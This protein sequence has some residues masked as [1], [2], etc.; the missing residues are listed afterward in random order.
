MQKLIITVRMNEYAM[1]DE[2]PNVPWSPDEIAEDAQEC[3]EAGAACVHWHGRDPV[4]GSPLNT[5]ETYRDAILKIRERSD[6]MVDPTLGYVT[7]TP[8]QRRIEHVLELAKDPATRPELA[9]VDMASINVDVYDEVEKRFKTDE[10]VFLNPTKILMEFTSKLQNAGVK[11][12]HTCWNIS[13]TRTVGAF[14]DMGLIKGPAY[15]C[16]LLSGSGLLAAHPATPRGLQ[17]HVDFLPKNGAIQWSTGCYPGSVMPVA[18][19]AIALGG[20]ISVGIGDHPYKE[21]GAPRN[22]EVVRRIVELA[23]SIGREVATPTEARTILGI[24]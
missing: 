7:L 21:L 1:R 10:T 18:G 13:S 4:D 11:T 2:N 15:M 22:A 20:H 17:A 19:M 14:I 6:I 16:L 8:P 24:S 9:P 12:V 23:R 3:R 5:F